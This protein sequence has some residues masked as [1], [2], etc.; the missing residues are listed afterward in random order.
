MRSWVSI[1]SAVLLAALIGYTVVSNTDPVTVVLPM[2]KWQTKSWAAMIAA[3]IVG[4]VATSLIV[5][6]P[7][8][9]LKLQARRQTKRI[10]ELE[11]EVHGLRT[12]PIASDAP[13]PTTAQKV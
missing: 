9:R 13:A 2:W 3:A 10:A 1:G 7:M 4:S 11:Q 6:W 12:L 8:V 5:S